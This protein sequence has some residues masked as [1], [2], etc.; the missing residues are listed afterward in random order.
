VGANFRDISNE[1]FFL[2]SHIFH[3]PPQSTFSIQQIGKLCAVLSHV[4]RKYFKIEKLEKV[5]CL[6][7]L[8]ISLKTKRIFALT[9]NI[10]VATNEE[11]KL[12]AS[13]KHRILIN[14]HHVLHN[15]AHL[16]S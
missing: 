4:D 7:P 8:V 16:M 15:Y 9:E 5:L 10:A 13:L 14:F 6:S 3:S 11:I 12:L 2:P 1:K